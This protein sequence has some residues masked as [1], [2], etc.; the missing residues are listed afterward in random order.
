MKK[1]TKQSVKTTANSS[2]Q[3]K[4]LAKKASPAK[5]KSAKKAPASKKPTC[6][7]SECKCQKKATSVKKAMRKTVKVGKPSR[8]PSKKA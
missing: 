7:C 1:Q 6:K 4:A 5:A 2:K 3:Y 8:K